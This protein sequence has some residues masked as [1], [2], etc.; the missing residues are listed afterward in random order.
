[1]SGLVVLSGT[2]AATTLY[3]SI[4]IPKVAAIEKS[5]S[6]ITKAIG[7]IKTVF[8]EF[9]E[10]WT[11]A[12][13]TRLNLP[14]ISKR[15]RIQESSLGITGVFKEL[16]DIRYSLLNTN[17][18]LFELLKMAC[19]A[20][21][22]GVGFSLVQPP[23]F[24]SFFEILPMA[25]FA[26]GTAIFAHEFIHDM[27]ANKY[28][29]DTRFEIWPLGVGFMLLSVFFGGVFAAFMNSE[30]KGKTKEHGV[31]YLVGPLI[32]LLLAVIFFRISYFGG[33][34]GLLGRFGAAINITIAAY[35]LLPMKPVDG[36]YIYKWNKFWWTILAI[37]CFVIAASALEGVA[38]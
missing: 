35:N 25:L 38:I 10:D 7:A 3:P 1:M 27:V 11:V 2:G 15:R 37:P 34:L 21:L 36:Y 16:D 4:T 22:L 29:V 8:G 6:F 19:C 32:N 24:G 26:V 17:V 13:H 14:F 5:A 30:I 12:L 33:S 28:G 18:S 9:F 31:I 20:T 23:E